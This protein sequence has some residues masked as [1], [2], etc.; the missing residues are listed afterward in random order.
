MITFFSNRPL[1]N[2]TVTT[3]GRAALPSVYLE[4]HTVSIV[5]SVE[6]A[7]LHF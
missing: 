6:T 7:L 3:I 1:H 4:I 2:E 5:E